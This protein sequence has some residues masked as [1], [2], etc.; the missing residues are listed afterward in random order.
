M[1]R[2]LVCS[3][4]ALCACGPPLFTVGGQ[5][6]GLSGDTA[7]LRLGDQ[8]LEVSG[9]ASFSFS[10]PLEDGSDFEVTLAVPPRHHDCELRDAE[11]TIQGQDVSTVR[12]ICTPR[13]VELV[14]RVQGLDGELVLDFD[15]APLTF[16]Q[17]GFYPLQGG[18]SAG[19]T[20]SLSLLEEPE[21][22]SCRSTAWQGQVGTADVLISVRCAQ[23]RNLGGTVSGLGAQTVGIALDQ[24][25][26]R[27]LGD[28]DFVF[29]HKLI[30]GDRW[31]LQLFDVP[32]AYGCRIFPS[33]GRITDRSPRVR[34][35]CVRLLYLEPEQ[36]PIGVIGQPDLL[37]IAPH[38]G[39]EPGSDGFDAPIGAPL[40]VDGHT[41]IADPLSHRVLIFEGL[42]TSS[43][44]A[45]ALL[46]Q[47]DMDHVEPGGAFGRLNEPVGV[48]SDGQRL[49]VVERGNHRISVWSELPT[50]AEP[51]G[52]SDSADETDPEE[53]LGPGPHFVLGHPNEDPAEPGCSASRLNG[54]S[55]VEA[56][57][58]RFFVADTLNN[59]V[60]IWFSF[61]SARTSPDVV[62]GQP[63]RALCEPNQGEGEDEPTA[64]HLW[65][66]T[67]VSFDGQRLYVADHGNRRVL[68]WNS[69]PT[70]SGRPADRVLGQ[71]DLESYFDED[72]PIDADR[73][74]APTH[75]HSTGRQLLV[76][77]TSRVL[78]WRGRPSSSGQPA[79]QVL[80]Q[81]DLQSSDPRVDPAGGPL[82][83]AGLAWIEGRL[84]V[85]DPDG[86]R[87]LV[88]DSAAPHGDED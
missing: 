30:E 18:L 33:S 4:L 83:P 31:Q 75:V 9:T 25:A 70:Q 36:S 37:Q 52:E 1:S 64:A 55:A 65:H 38:R 34:V 21:S 73:L 46:G 86:A 74:I 69:L 84:Y 87:V 15:G 81:P 62:L 54:P 48:A 40:W 88:Y 76:S 53:P 42:P 11:G 7:V 56:A 66:P 6:E 72:D 17:D 22:Q 10:D 68:V 5:A 41:Y 58:G 28:G 39:G 19:D 20:W 3:L 13:D 85:S 79:D 43:D 32:E 61:P 80:G 50:S 47:D 63:N 16:Q 23:A 12:L 45:V 2:A 57:Y 82:S 14:L 8:R 59:R 29:D 51:E 71:P 49:A 24:T 67:D 27:T 35:P 26:S 77:D 44:T 60:L 78:L